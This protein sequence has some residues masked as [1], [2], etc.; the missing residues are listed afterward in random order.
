LLGTATCHKPANKV[1]PASAPVAKPR[2]GRYARQ[3]N[4]LVSAFSI[5][6]RA[7]ARRAT[8]EAFPFVI[9]LVRQP[10]SVILGFIP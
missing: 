8:A 10:A 4:H 5:S 2:F 1:L 7:I 3:F 6:C 9:L